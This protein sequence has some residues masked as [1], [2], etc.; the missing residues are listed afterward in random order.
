MLVVVVTQE[1]IDKGRRNSPYTCPVARAC[2]NVPEQRKIIAMVSNRSVILGW[3]QKIAPVLSSSVA[4]KMPENMRDW[5]RRY[6]ESEK[7][8]PMIF[9]LQEA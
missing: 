8:E 7:V 2:G 9:F 6:D 5:I 3:P 1:D 4:Y